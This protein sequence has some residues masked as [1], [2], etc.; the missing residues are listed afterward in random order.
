MN[1]LSNGE[2]LFNATALF[3]QVILVCHF[4]I[5]KW[6]FQL[7]IKYGWI[8]YA[9]SLPATAVSIYLLLAGYSPYLWLGGFIYLVWASFGY[10]VEYVRKIQWRTPPKG[11]VL[12]PYVTLY[13]ATVMFYWWPLAMVYKPLWYINGVLFLISTVLNITSHKGNASIEYRQGVYEN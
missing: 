12:V 8:V 11:M 9:C 4:A 1:N 7:V 6:R 13:L 10:Y 5:R 3:F 2:I